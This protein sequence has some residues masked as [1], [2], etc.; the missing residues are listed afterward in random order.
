MPGPWGV[1]VFLA[2]TALVCVG[3]SASQVRTVTSPSSVASVSA[4]ASLSSQASPSAASPTDAAT[5]DRRAE[6]DYCTEFLNDPRLTDLPDL[7][8]AF[9]VGDRKATT[10][11][12]AAAD[13]LDSF[14]DEG[15]GS[16]AA[17]TATAIR[18][19]V[20]HPSEY[21]RLT[22]VATTANQL[23]KQVKKECVS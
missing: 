14:A 8:A 2:V 5:A 20:A 15:V 17:D 6:A 4:G 12:T 3:C 18:N 21:S 1:K 23:D 9:A 7:L 13:A 10:A 22:Q 11:L 19:L 16:I